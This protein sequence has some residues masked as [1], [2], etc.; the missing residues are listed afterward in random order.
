VDRP[1][2]VFDEWASDQDPAFKQIFY[3]D[4]LPALK[5]RGKAVI[6]ISHDDRYYR[7]ADRI[8]KLERGKI[9]YD[10]RREPSVVAGKDSRVIAPFGH[11]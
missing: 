10:I 2:Y 8:V 5:A 11:I 7:V 3:G 1:I 4:I 6:V 9:E